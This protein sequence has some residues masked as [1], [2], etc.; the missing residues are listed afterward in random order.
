[1]RNAS[2]R[3][4]AALL[5]LLTSGSAVAALAPGDYARSFAIGGAIRRYD[6][7][8]PPGYTG[9]S[10][11]PLVLDFHGLSSNRMQ[12]AGLSGFKT[13]SDT[14]GFIV[15]YPQGL[16][17][18]P[19]DASNGF[20]GPSWNAGPLCCGQA[21]GASSDDVAFARA[22]VAAIAGEVN[23]DLH[24]VYATGLSNG[25]AF[26]QRLACEAAD[27][28]A[29]AAP[30]A[31]PIALASL[32]D[33]QPSRPVAVLSFAGLTDTLDPYAGGPFMLGGPLVT[34]PSAQDSFARWRAANGCSG[35]VPDQSVTTGMSLCET[36]T[37]CAGGVDVGLCSI[38]A[39]SAP[40]F[41]GHV[42]YLNPDLNL[43]TVAW[44]FLS[45][46]TLPAGIPT[47]TERAVDGAKL[48]LKERFSDPNQKKIVAL[49]QDADI[50]RTWGRSGCTWRLAAGL[51]CRADDRFH[52]RRPAEQ[53]MATDGIDAGLQGPPLSQ[54]SLQGGEGE[55]RGD[56]EGGLPVEGA[57]DWLL[58]Q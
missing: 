6:L 35:A 55:A 34:L 36:Y 16:F 3:F 40:P 41:P 2:R 13:L 44:Q 15:A 26:S 1:M 4:L 29:A 46:F 5:A 24:R 51:Q 57:A 7:H 48:V 33:C 25:G 53:R 56:V 19:N 12:Q 50:H 20:L 18:G 11:T 10:A 54:R 43:A 17:G 52:V 58:A 28:F 31:F 8:V 22:V 39:S 38:T 47:H 37:N 30:M 32:T 49:I 14:Q 9:A 27:V 21:V 23:V 45:Q 42:L